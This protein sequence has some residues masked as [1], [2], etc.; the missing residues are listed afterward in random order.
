MTLLR[1]FENQSRDWSIFALIFGDF[2]SMFLSLYLISF[3]PLFAPC[4]ILNQIDLVLPKCLAAMMVV[5]L[6]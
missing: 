2:C 4:W 6:P 3:H 1:T 5:S